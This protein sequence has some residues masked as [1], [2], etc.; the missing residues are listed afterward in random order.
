MWV[1]TTHG[2]FS[3]V[4]NR[5]DPSQVMVRARVREDLESL[6]A[7]LD[8]P[9]PV[10]GQ[11]TDYPWRTFVSKEEWAQWLA[12]AAREI[13]YDNFKN[14][15]AREQ[16]HARASVYG[17]VWGALKRLEELEAEGL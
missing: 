15:V 11:G 2:F 13:E 10:Y 5:D 3:A 1:L 4:E 16:G 12:G 17:E 8:G 6:C 9:E 14:A 7:Q